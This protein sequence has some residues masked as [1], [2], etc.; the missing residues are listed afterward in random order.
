M[1]TKII[2]WGKNFKALFAK[3]F[4]QV[5]FIV[6]FLFLALMTLLPAWQLLP[7]IKEAGTIPLHYNIHFGVDSFGVWWRVFMIPVSGAVILIVNFLLAVAFWKRERVL[8]K[9]L[10]ATA[11]LVQFLLFISMIFVVLFNLAYG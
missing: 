4:F 10:A 11:M 8:S 2:Q 9:F 3:R 7:D 5:T 6:A 1:K